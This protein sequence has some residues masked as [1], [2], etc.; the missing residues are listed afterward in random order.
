MS[1]RQLRKLQKQKELEQLQDEAAAESGE[2]EDE[3]QAP[4]S[5]AKPNLFAAL[6]GDG[7]Q[8]T[9]QDE[10]EEADA[11]PDPEVTPV[12][13]ALSS[14][15]S[16]KKK[17]KKKAKAK[18]ETPA[19]AEDDDDAEEDEI[20]K[21]MKA[22]NIKAQGSASMEE[23]QTVRNDNELLG[24][25]PYHLKALNEMRNLFGREVIEAADAEEEQENN[26][27]GRRQQMP[28]QV[29]L[30]TFLREPPGAP[31]LP[32]V[33]LRRNLFIQGKEHWPKQ[34]AGGLTMKEI[35]KAPDG[36]STEYAY[37]HDTTY[38]SMQSYFFACVQIGDPMRM[39]HLLKQAR[40]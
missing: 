33:S 30:E 4:A 5:R 3:P 25:N 37:V 21:A 18:A 29:D 28:R 27:R 39:V 22:L 24:I 15:K 32:E 36:S 9:D 20:D 12:E 38:D 13:P 40:K 17:K 7:D 35:Q 1:S 14:K 11:E 16:K 10:D 8:D 2:S 6:G 23:Q 34:S 31:K 26:R 19:E